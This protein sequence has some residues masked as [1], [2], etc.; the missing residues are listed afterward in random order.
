[1]LQVADVSSYGFDPLI[2][3]LE[4]FLLLPD[5]NIPLTGLKAEGSL[6]FLNFG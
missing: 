4:L 1:L 6:L 5:F 3:L 2:Q